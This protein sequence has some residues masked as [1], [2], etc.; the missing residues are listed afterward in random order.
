M[1][2]PRSLLSHC[3]CVLSSLYIRHLQ[4]RQLRLSSP[5]RPPP[6]SRSVH[7]AASNQSMSPSHAI[8]QPAGRTS[9]SSTRLPSAA[10]RRV[11]TD[12]ISLDDFVLQQVKDLISAVALFIAILPQP[13]LIPTGSTTRHLSFEAFHCIVLY[14]GLVSLSWQQL[15]SL[16]RLFNF[17]CGKLRCSVKSNGS[18]SI[19]RSRKMG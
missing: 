17:P 1:L 6:V 5:P 3:F 16:C 7:S 14:C 11:E 12:E 10:S 18:S 9:G 4:E 13:A 19:A 15:T 8:A 2:P